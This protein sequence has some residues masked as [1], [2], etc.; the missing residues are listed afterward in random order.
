MPTIYVDHIGLNVKCF[1]FFFIVLLMY[2]LQIHIRA[3][4]KTTYAN[5]TAFLPVLYLGIICV[6]LEQVR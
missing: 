6:I 5:T 1:N 3:C 4:L 2:V